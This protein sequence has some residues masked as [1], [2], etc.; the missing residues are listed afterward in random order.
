LEENTY[1]PPTPAGGKYLN[2]ALRQRYPTNYLTKSVYFTG[3]E[4]SYNATFDTSSYYTSVNR[5][6]CDGCFLGSSVHYATYEP[7]DSPTYVNVSAAATYKNF[8]DI[9]TCYAGSTSVIGSW[10]ND[11]WSTLNDYVGLSFDFFL[12]E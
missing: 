1:V 10:A 11:Y 2:M 8:L 4:P 7:T 5:K 3:G 12:V 9:N 6:D